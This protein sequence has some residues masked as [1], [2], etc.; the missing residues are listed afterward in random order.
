MMNKT[1]L[2]EYI[3][4]LLI[5][6]GLDGF[7]VPY[8]RDELLEITGE[9]KDVVEARKFL[10]RHLLQLEQKGLLQT[11]GQ[12]R[13]KTYHKSELFKTTKFKPKRR[14]SQKIEAV[15]KSH[16]KTLSLDELVWERRKYEAELAIALAEIEEFQL[17][18]ERL[19]SQKSSLLRLSE[20][21]REKSVRYLAKINV[22]NQ[23]LKLST[24]VDI[25]C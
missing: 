3:Y 15:E 4:T 16:N 10:Y 24:Y 14:K 11:K 17:L 19:P 9:F 1:L 5:E 13:K 21:T 2:N 6:K 18:S 8:L 25:K 23:A 20:E 7:T 22:L 12:G